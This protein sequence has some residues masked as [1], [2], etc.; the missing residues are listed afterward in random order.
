MP[1][2]QIHC[3]SVPQ[4]PIRL[5]H[6]LW[7]VSERPGSITPPQSASS[8]LMA[9]RAPPELQLIGPNDLRLLLLYRC[10][11]PVPCRTTSR[12]CCCGADI[13][14][15]LTDPMFQ[16]QYHGKVIPMAIK[17]GMSRTVLAPGHHGACGA[18]AYHD[19]DLTAV[20]DRAWTAGV[21]RI[22][23]TATNAAEARRA[24]A[25]ARTDGGSA[26]W[27]SLPSTCSTWL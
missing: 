11:E 14:A 19:A 9:M 5:K 8:G 12:F 20:L 27:K 13:G 16:G 23:I 22:I 21:T 3:S 10:G 7:T 4:L 6:A 25:M 2:R 24:L 17:L 1:Q 26:S 18:Q 15:N